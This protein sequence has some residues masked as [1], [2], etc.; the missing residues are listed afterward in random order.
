MKNADARENGG[1]APVSANS[2]ESLAGRLK[3]AAAESGEKV[4][5]EIPQTL[6]R[7]RILLIVVAVT[8]PLFLVGVLIILAKALL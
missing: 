4:F 2:G 7:L 6:R 1:P 3:T 5:A 8:L